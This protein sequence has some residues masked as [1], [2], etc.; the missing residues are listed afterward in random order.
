MRAILLLSCTSAAAAALVGGSASYR[1]AASTRASAPVCA[2]EKEKV[3]DVED[4]DAVRNRELSRLRNQAEQWLAMTSAIGL[5]GD[6]GL[7][8]FA[9]PSGWLAAPSAPPSQVFSEEQLI[10]EIEA[11]EPTLYALL[12]ACA[13]C[14]PSL[15]TP[16]AML[17][18][19]RLAAWTDEEEWVR[20]LDEWEGEVT[21]IRSSNPG[22]VDE[23]PS[24][25]HAFG[26]R[27]GTG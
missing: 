7:Q 3:I 27:A 14:A 20:P 24:A 19:A 5:A 23:R 18:L 8:P 11:R 25:T 1:T 26:R 10:M 2:A 17:P 12:D 6:A 15:C 21:P 22:P 4:E 16:S 13:E 9:V